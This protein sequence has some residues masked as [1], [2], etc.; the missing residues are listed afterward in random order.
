M[1][2][3]LILLLLVLIP[4][5]T[6]C[7]SFYIQQAIET[8]NHGEPEIANTRPLDIEMKLW[9]ASRFL[10]VP[11]GPPNASLAA[12]IIDPPRNQTPRG[13]VLVIHGYGDRPF[14]M[15]GKAHDLADHGYRAVLVALRGYS[16][17][18][19]DYRTF[20]VVERNDLRQ[21][22]D[23]LDNQHLLVGK[24]GVWGMSYGSSMAMELAGVDDRVEAVVAV[25]GF[26]SMRT[27]VPEFIRTFSGPA[28][29]GMSEN[30]FQDL[31]DKAGQTAQ[32]DP[33]RASALNALKHTHAAVLIC[34]GKDDRIVPF[35]H[36]EQLVGVANEHSELFALPGYGHLLIWLDPDGRVR[37]KGLAWLDDHLAADR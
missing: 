28:T 15:L 33:D 8:P 5:I 35:H 19:G 4:T 11:V 23:E 37:Q 22:V 32:F 21:L 26:A 10:R 1:K 20:G 31:I 14:F 25:A 9:G 18:T 29:A 30:D 17:S 27:I 2:P 34:H 24:L 12:W 3:R 13:T 7:Q 16:Y 36:A 6:G